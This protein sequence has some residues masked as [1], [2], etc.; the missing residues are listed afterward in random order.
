MILFEETFLR[1]L[2]KNFHFSLLAVFL[3][4]HVSDFSATRNPCLRFSFVDSQNF[5]FQTEEA[6][7]WPADKPSILRLSRIPRILPPRNRNATSRIKNFLT[8]RRGKKWDRAAEVLVCG[9]SLARSSSLRNRIKFYETRSP[10]NHNRYIW[11]GN[12]HK[13]IVPQTCK[14]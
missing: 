3:A 12:M 4:N 9:L 10:I 6:G 2:V 5:T 11:S 8:F 7:P 13:R 14:G 1:F